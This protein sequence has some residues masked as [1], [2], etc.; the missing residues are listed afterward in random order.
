MAPPELSISTHEGHP[1]EECA[2]VDA[3]LGEFND[4]AAPL[5]EVQPLSCFARSPS[6]QVGG[7]AVGRRW[8]SC[9]ELQQLWVEPTHR[10]KGIG[11]QLI[12][13]FEARAKAHGCISFY[14][15]TLSFQA[16]GLYSSLG[17]KVAYEYA[18]FPHGIVKYHMVKQVG[19]GASAA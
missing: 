2:L 10:R 13:A 5:H 3:G 8:G 12:Q 6:G 18:G 16:P 15:E 9:C 17:Y 11:A 14:L 19:S 7:G 4:Q 1:P